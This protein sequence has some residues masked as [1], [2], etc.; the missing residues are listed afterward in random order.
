MNL[1]KQRL[2]NWALFLLEKIWL[3]LLFASNRKVTF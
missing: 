1:W 3:A 2:N